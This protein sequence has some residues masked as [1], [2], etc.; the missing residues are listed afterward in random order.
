LGAGQVG[1]N[2]I[3]TL[4]SQL[5]Y[6]GVDRL[7][8]AEIQFGIDSGL[9]K[10]P[11]TC[12]TVYNPFPDLFDYLFGGNIYA[13]PAPKDKPRGV[14]P[15]DQAGLSTGLIHGIKDGIRAGPKDWVGI[16]PN[17]DIWT[18]NSDGNAEEAGNI[19]DYK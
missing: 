14:V 2:T 10:K 12:G 4:N 18:S 9:I 7:T 15:I 19:S 17:G 16:G 11:C 5:L 3:R 1:H 6:S 8:S 13:Q